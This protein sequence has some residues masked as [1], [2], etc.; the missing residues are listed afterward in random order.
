MVQQRQ[1]PMSSNNLSF[2]APSS[3]VFEDRSHSPTGCNGPTNNAILPISDGGPNHQNGSSSSSSE[4]HYDCRQSPAQTLN[5]FMTH[6]FGGGGGGGGGG[7]CNQSASNNHLSHHHEPPDQSE[8]PVP[9][10][11]RSHSASPCNDDQQSR[12]GTPATPATPGGHI[13]NGTQLIANGGNRTPDVVDN[14]NPLSRPRDVA[15]FRSSPIV[16]TSTIISA[17]ANSCLADCEA[18]I[19]PQ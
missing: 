5:A 2:S 13:I 15:D 6:Q 19:P 14:D 3:P 4:P 18:L 11:D 1:Q 17:P 8:S 16:N 10:F 7:G 12:C 9:P